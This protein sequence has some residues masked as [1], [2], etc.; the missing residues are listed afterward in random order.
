MLQYLW[1]INRE[2]KINEEKIRYAHDEEFGKVDASS[3]IILKRP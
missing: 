1:G 3:T 2:V